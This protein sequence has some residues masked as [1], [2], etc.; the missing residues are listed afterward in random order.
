VVENTLAQL[1][2]GEGYATRVHKTFP[3]GEAL[4]EEMPVGA[5]PW[6][7]SRERLVREIDPRTDPQSTLPTE[8]SSTSSRI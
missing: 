6:S 1:L 8:S 2:E 7:T 4:V 5:V 3:M